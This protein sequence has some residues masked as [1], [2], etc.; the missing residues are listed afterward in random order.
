MVHRTD[1]AGGSVGQVSPGGDRMCRRALNGVPLEDNPL[2]KA[3]SSSRPGDKKCCR[4]M[5]AVLPVH[6]IYLERLTL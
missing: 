3:L 2:P 4:F 6:A 1:I 5:T